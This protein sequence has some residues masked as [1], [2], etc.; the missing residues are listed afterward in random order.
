[1][2]QPYI[3][4]GMPV[5]LD[6]PRVYGPPVS[7]DL[8][9]PGYVPPADTK[10]P[11]GYFTGGQKGLPSLTPMAVTTVPTPT[12]TPTRAVPYGL[13]DDLL[14]G[15]ALVDPDA[16]RSD[17]DRRWRELFGGLDTKDSGSA[18]SP[19]VPL[20]PERSS[21]VTDH[22]PGTVSSSFFKSH[23]GTRPIDRN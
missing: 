17:D 7:D 22:S 3:D 23:V 6:I 13:L 16:D 20:P 19:F 5:P 12:P 4:A 9:S 10:V 8:P 11:D 14:E 2:A 18:A 1:L 15:V 21:G